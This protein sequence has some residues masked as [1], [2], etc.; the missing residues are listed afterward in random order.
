MSDPKGKQEAKSLFTKIAIGLLFIL[1]AFAI[2]QLILNTFTKGGVR[3]DFS[4]LDPNKK[5][6]E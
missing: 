1:F 3:G 6:Q 4:G 5:I 2:V